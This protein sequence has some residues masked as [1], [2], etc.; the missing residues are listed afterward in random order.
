MTVPQLP[1][2]LERTVIEYAAEI[3]KPMALKLILIS[4]EVKRW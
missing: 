3:D 4:R 1:Y 2:D